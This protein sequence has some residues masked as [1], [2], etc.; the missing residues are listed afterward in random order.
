VADRHL[1]DPSQLQ[2]QKTEIGTVK[3]GRYVR[4]S[5]YMLG[6]HCVNHKGPKWVD[7]GPT[8][9]ANISRN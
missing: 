5:T 1:F 7:D 3:I 2:E 8:P 6:I 4:V 9:N